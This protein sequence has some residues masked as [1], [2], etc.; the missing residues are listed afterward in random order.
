MVCPPGLEPGSPASEAG[1]LSVVLWAPEYAAHNKRDSTVSQESPRFA[2]A[3][4]AIHTNF[5]LSG[6]FQFSETFDAQGRLFKHGFV[7]T[8]V[9][10]WHVSARVFETYRSRKIPEAGAKRGALEEPFM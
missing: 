6:F 1:T 4:G 3:L 8:N 5:A 9:A 10:L 2:S 7:R